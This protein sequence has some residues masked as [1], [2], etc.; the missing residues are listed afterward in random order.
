MVYLIFA[1]SLLIPLG[2]SPAPQNTPFPHRT[3][4]ISLIYKEE[5]LKSERDG[6]E[7]KAK[8]IEESKQ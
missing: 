1:D 3:Q 4:P 6:W 7:A 5:K 8:E 2:G